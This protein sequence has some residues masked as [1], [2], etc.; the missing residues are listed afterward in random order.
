MMRLEDRKLLFE[1]V[2]RKIK[3]F[4]SRF[5]WRE[6]L[7]FLFFLLL[8]FIFWTLQSMQEEYEIQLG[9]PVSY[10]DI[11]RD[12][13]FLQT[14][15][16][17]IK[18]RIRDKG[19]VLLNYTLGQKKAFL[20]VHIPETPAPNHTVL[21]NARDME[22]MI[23]KQLIPSTS[24]LSFDPQEIEVSYSKLKKKRLPVR[25][26]GEIRP[27]P[28]FLLS[29]N[30]TVSPPEVD[31]FA[32]DV[33]LESLTNV[34]TV[35]TEIKKGN[36][37]IVRKLKLQEIEGARFEPQIVS[38]EIPIEEYTEKTLEIPIV[39]RHTPPGYAIRM[40]PSVVR[41]TCNVPLSAFKE[42]SEKDFSAEVV[43]GNPEQNVSGML[44][45]RLTKKP[46]RIDRV[47]LSLDSI[48]FIL[49]PVR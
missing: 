41:I 3:P 30:I 17:E 15:P 22:S 43:A 31:V 38:V 47:T 18:V 24:L 7:I 14:P 32:G 6:V 25:F 16:S 27:E 37:R 28:G 1:S 4:L 39:C 5:Q 49:E 36:K 45:V 21:L 2:H 9:I 20:T 46:D 8:S 11:P 26:D 23:M 48:E 35:Y 29:G 33:L 44:P 40:F 42:L 34:S 10:K 12:M 13:A 19:S